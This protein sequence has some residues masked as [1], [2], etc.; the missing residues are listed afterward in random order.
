MVSTPRNPFEPHFLDG[1]GLVFGGE[2]AS[3]SGKGHSANGEEVSADGEG[4]CQLSLKLD[5]FSQ[6]AH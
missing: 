3:A 6:K 5:V 2:G 1:E 4:N